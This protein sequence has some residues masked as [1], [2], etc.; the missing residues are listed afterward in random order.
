MLEF[1]LLAWLFG[2]T[3]N[4]KLLS[5]PARIE[6]DRDYKLLEKR[7][8]GVVAS[9]GQILSKAWIK[10]REGLEKASD[11]EIKQALAGM[12]SQNMDVL[13]AI[14]RIGSRYHLQRVYPSVQELAEGLRLCMRST[15][16]EIRSRAFSLLARLASDGRGCLWLKST[17]Y[18]DRP[19]D[20]ADSY[21]ELD[22]VG[23][24]FA[25]A[26]CE[27]ALLEE[28][29]S[30]V[31]K[32]M[33]SAMKLYERGFSEKSYLAVV[34]LLQDELVRDTAFYLLYRD[35]LKH[36]AIADQVARGLVKVL[37]QMENISPE[38]L[39]RIESCLPSPEL[40]GELNG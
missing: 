29:D 10:L 24:E 32:A 35:G 17:Y 18:R 7:A 4:E 3:R 26:Q 11:Q 19:Y 15:D 23:V 16:P 5:V 40:P 38:M 34:P 33:V 31:L 36:A 21:D 25:A 2:N 28:Q 27:K 13:P 20:L 39:A 6:E 37:R 14:S 1:S 22:K 30:L 12:G 8:G 9:C